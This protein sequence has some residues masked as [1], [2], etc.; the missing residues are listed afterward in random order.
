[1]P[2]RGG[3]NQQSRQ[4]DGQAAQAWQQ[5]HKY[6]LVQELMHKGCVRESEALDSFEQLTGSR[7]ADALQDML[8]E[9]NAAMANLGLKLKSLQYAVDKQKYIAFINTLDDEPSKLATHYSPAQREFFKHVLETIAADT[10]AENGVGSAPG[11]QLLN[12][13]LGRVPAGLDE[14]GKAAAEAAAAAVKKL[15][16]TDKENTLRQLVTDNWL[17]HSQQLSGH[18]CIG[19]SA[20]QLQDRWSAAE[21]VAL[22]N[23]LCRHGDNW[24]SVAAEVDTKP[25][26]EVTA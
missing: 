19:V 16:K 3:G 23:A 11:I 10:T 4:G 2:R 1:M 8:A 5:V 14:E 20:L 9:Q 15:T 6:A 17:R 18:Y 21:L 26:H 7:N 22:K 24:N 25:K 13:D 12:M